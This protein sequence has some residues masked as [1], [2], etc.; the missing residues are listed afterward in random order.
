MART[1][2]YAHTS[3]DQRNA[4]GPQV[5]LG[6][7]SGGAPPAYSRDELVGPGLGKIMRNLESDDDARD[8][9]EVVEKSATPLDAALAALGN[10]GPK[11]RDRR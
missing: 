9:I 4:Y 3:P 10:H 2:D 7:P 1:G 5:A 6:E 11:D 8:L